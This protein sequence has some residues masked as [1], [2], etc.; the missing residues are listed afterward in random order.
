MDATDL[1]D[2]PEG[3]GLAGDELHRRDNWTECGACGYDVPVDY[4]TCTFCGAEL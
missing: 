3:T 4:D 2:T 1:M